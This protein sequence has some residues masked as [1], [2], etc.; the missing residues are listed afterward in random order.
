MEHSDWCGACVIMHC[1][2][3]KLA[4]YSHSCELRSHDWD[5]TFKA[6]QNA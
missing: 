1:G 2:A 3:G 4:L 6:R 5:V